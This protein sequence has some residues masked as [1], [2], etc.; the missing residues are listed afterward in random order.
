M[1]QIVSFGSQQAARNCIT[2]CGEGERTIE[3]GT[4]LSCERGDGTE[5]D[6]CSFDGEECFPCSL[7]G[8]NACRKSGILRQDVKLLT[9]V[10]CSLI[11]ITILSQLI[12]H[13]VLGQLFCISLHVSEMFKYANYLF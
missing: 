12:N 10:N 6:K 7:E 13:S 8:D 3:W 1:S 5:K 9:R 2:Y 11:D 4:E